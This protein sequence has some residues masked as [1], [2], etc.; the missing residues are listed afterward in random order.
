MGFYM[1]EVIRSSYY[2][3]KK[4][5]VISNG[6]AASLEFYKSSALPIV[7]HFRYIETGVGDNGGKVFHLDFDGCGAVVTNF[8]VSQ[9]LQQTLLCCWWNTFVEQL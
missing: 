8:V 9:K 7:Q 3:L 5:G 1:A 4:H 2:K 6:D